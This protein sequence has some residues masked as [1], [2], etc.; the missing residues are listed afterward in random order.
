MG[1]DN[2]FEDR[3]GHQAPFTLPEKKNLSGKQER[4]EKKYQGI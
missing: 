3:E 4:S 2:G 1:T